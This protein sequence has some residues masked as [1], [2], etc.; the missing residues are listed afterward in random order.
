ML[1]CTVEEDDGVTS[2]FISE[3]LH[4]IVENLIV[5]LNRGICFIDDM[6]AKSFPC[7]KILSPGWQHGEIYSQKLLVSE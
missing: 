1:T 2:H 5:A 4:E 3:L 7:S 6:L